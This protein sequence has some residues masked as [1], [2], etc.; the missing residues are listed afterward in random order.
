M[1]VKH[2]GIFLHLRDAALGYKDHVAGLNLD[3]TGE[4]FAR[5]HFLQVDFFNLD[6]ISVLA[7][8]QEN[9]R[10]LGAWA[11]AAG[12]RDSFAQFDVAAQIVL[13]GFLNFAL[14]EEERLLEI[15]DFDADIRFFQHTRVLAF[16][17]LLQLGK[18]Q[19]PG[20]NFAYRAQCH[21]T[22]GLNGDGLIEFRDVG[23]SQI[24]SVAVFQL[25]PGLLGAGD[26]CDCN[27]KCGSKSKDLRHTSSTADS[28][29]KSGRSQKSASEAALH[30]LG[31]IHVH[32]PGFRE[33]N[34]AALV[35]S[36]RGRDQNSCM[37]KT[38]SR[39]PSESERMPKDANEDVKKEQEKPGRE[40][41]KPTVQF[42]EGQKFTSDEDL[43]RRTASSVMPHEQL[44]T[45]ELFSALQALKAEGTPDL[46]KE[47]QM[48]Q[49]ELE[50]QNRELRQTQ[51]QLAH[52][53]MRYADLYDFSPIGYASLDERGVIEEIN[54]T[55]GQLLGD[56]PHNLVGRAFTEFIPTGQTRSFRDH[57]QKCKC[58]SQKKSIELQ[59]TASNGARTDIQLFTILTSDADRH[60]LQFRTAIIDIT[61]RKHAESVAQE[62]HKQLEQ[63]VAERTAELT[64]ERLQRE[65][66]QRFLYEVSSVLGMSLDYE[67]T[68]WTLARAALPH[69]GDGAAVDMVQDDGSLKRLAIAHVEAEKEPALWQ[70]PPLEDTMRVVRTSQAVLHGR[71][72]C[73]PLVMRGKTIGALSLQREREGRE[74]NPFL[75]A[76]AEDLA[77]RAAI[78]LDNATL[79]MKEL[80]ANQIKDEFLAL[81]SHELRTPLT[82]ILG[83]TYKLRSSRPHDRD[84]HT[85][86]DMIERNAR[87][88]ARIVEELLDISRMTTGKMEFNRQ[89]T[90]LRAIIQNAI[91]V[92]RP[93]TQALRIN[94]SVSLE[95]PK[96]LIWCDRDRIQQVI[97][98]LLSNAIKFTSQGGTIEVCLENS[99]GWAHIRI[100][101]TG[102]GIS[103]AFLPHVFDRF[104]QAGSFSTRM[105]CGLGIGLSIVRY[106]VE[107]HGGRVHAESRGEGHG[108]TFTVDLPYA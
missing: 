104:R 11:E 94:L 73:V 21:V 16:D 76:L 91:E 39:Q 24:Q 49:L 23:K 64:S 1:P 102:V 93:S 89:P 46:I 17:G 42:D 48:Q 107:R 40:K 7:P 82:P 99:S 74:Y 85:A 57:L 25:V 43:K 103:P 88:Q 81:V 56:T 83:A 28:E 37:E 4:I 101:D 18:S 79:Y 69:L 15:L 96:R 53:R 66:A 8:E 80:E 33:R 106:I 52:S 36:N 9:L 65:D 78:A 68:L 67:I 32:V 98:N 27:G 31:Q 84:L 54:I 55:G 87:A 29:P 62:I 12:Y 95:D 3:V 51:Q 44:T 108:A 45:N 6:L 35:A 5:K 22:V 47:L 71:D 100:S 41:R 50:I 26:Q 77:D 61:K 14:R 34:E 58:S 70:S 92:V 90:D 60:T 10:V 105:H 30:N 59:L 2:C 75:L 97:W 19:S 63:I 20:S 72:M 13:A 86:L 38:M